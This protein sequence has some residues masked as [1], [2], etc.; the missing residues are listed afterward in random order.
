MFDSTCV[1]ASMCPSVQINIFH[2][3]MRTR[4]V[5]YNTLSD[6]CPFC[7]VKHGAMRGLRYIFRSD[8]CQC[9]HV[10]EWYKIR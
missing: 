5:E 4:G 8:P 1:Q 2:L 6:R 9:R 3:S 7:T 10:G